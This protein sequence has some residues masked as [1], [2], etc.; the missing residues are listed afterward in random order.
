VVAQLTTQHNYEEKTQE[1]ARELLAQTREKRSLW[2]KISDNLRWDD[3]LLD[4]AMASPGLRMQLFR[5]I[6]C[7]PALKS[8]AEIANHLQQYL[9]QENVEL[10]GAL[11][12]IL[13]FTD[14]HTPPAQLAA[15]TISKATETLAFKYISGETIEQ[16]IKAVERLR[17]EKMGFTI[18]LL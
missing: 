18:D 8:N 17:K 12:G 4:W 15:A 13:N 5:F 2:D 3:K 9:G 6:D 11:K 10:P 16:V 1:I 7:L 14:P